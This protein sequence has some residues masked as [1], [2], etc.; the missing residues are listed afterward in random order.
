[1][2]AMNQDQEPEQRLRDV[3]TPQQRHKTVFGLYLSVFLI[4]V[5]LIVFSI[6][7]NIY[8]LFFILGLLLLYYRF[9][10][11][12]VSASEAKFSHMPHI[13]ET[14]DDLNSASAK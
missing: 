4:I 3:M 6:M 5:C 12:L 2:L 1:M 8:P 13:S 14:S 9:I 10:D 11:D 7:K